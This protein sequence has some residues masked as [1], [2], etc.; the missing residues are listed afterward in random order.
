MQYAGSV[1]S[2][3]TGALA[4]PCV[5]HKPSRPEGTTLWCRRRLM[6]GLAPVDPGVCTEEPGLVPTAER[7]ADILTSAG[8]PGTQT[9]MDITVEP[10]M[11]KLLGLTPVLQPLRGR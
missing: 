10:L 8:V 2:Y 7:P 3:S 4:T 6:D 5:V 9:A 11:R 1:G